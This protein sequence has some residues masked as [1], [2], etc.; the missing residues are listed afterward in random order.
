MFLAAVFIGLLKEV[1]EM[2]TFVSDKPEAER[3][4]E[5]VAAGIKTISAFR[6]NLN[7]RH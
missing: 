4:S 1:D 7:L 5:G 3:S 6:K 2:I